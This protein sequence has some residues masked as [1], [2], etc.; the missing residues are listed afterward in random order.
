MRSFY[1][2]FYRAIE[3]VTGSGK[4]FLH[5]PYLDQND[6]DLVAK[7]IKSQFISTAGKSTTE[8]ENIISKFV[9]SKYCVSTTSGTSALQI[10]LLASGVKKD[11]E[12]FV[13]SLTFVGTANSISHCGA[14]PHFVDSNISDFGIDVGKLHDYLNKNFKL[15]KESLINKKTHRKV[16]AIVPVHI[17]GHSCAIEEINKLARKFNLKVIEDA[18]EALGSFKKSKHLGTFSL[19][20]CLSFNGNKIITTGAGGAIITNSFKHYKVA[21]H[22]I[23]T[24][25]VPHKFKYVHDKIGFNYRM[26]SLNAS[27]GIAQM[28]KLNKFIKAKRNLYLKYKNSFLNVDGIKIFKDNKDEVSNY[29]LQTAILDD[30]KKKYKENLIKFCISKNIFVR[31]AWELIS[32][33]KPYKNCPKMDLFGAK[34]IES[35]VINLPSSQ[36]LILGNN[37]I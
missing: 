16:K 2:S 15:T 9:K 32:D 25:K 5:E 30:K 34:N 19:F 1:N 11:D 13:P 22:L 12:V 28:Y 18:A 6:I 37:I 26:P 4:H 21:K 10:A 17:F 3:L 35:R 29:W 31:P 23:T 27:L 20:G 36:S 24:A 7:T 8:F 33:L 14:I